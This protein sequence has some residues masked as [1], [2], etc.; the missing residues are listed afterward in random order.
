[1]RTYKVRVIKVS[2]PTGYEKERYEKLQGE[3]K[4][5]MRSYKVKVRKV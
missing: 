1:M 4:K 3:R 5:G 2:E